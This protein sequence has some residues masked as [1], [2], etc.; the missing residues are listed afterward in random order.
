MEE[1]QVPEAG[2]QEGQE[3]VKAERNINYPAGVIKHLPEV[4]AQIFVLIMTLNN[5][6]LFLV[7]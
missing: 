7:T 2:G 3:K 4:D 5:A 6:A 1:R